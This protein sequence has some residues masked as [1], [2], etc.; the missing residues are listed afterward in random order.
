MISRQ[1]DQPMVC[2]GYSFFENGRLIIFRG[3]QE[4]A[5]IHAM[6]IWQTPFCSDAHY[7][8][9]DRGG[10]HKLADIGNR[11]LV[12]AISDLSQI[13]R[14]IANQQPSAAI[15]SDLIRTLDAVID[16]HHWLGDP[17]VGNMHDTLNTI[18]GT[19]GQVID[20]FEKVEQLRG[21][22]EQQLRQQHTAYEELERSLAI[23]GEHDVDALVGGLDSLRR[24]QGRVAGLREVRYINLEDVEELAATVQQRFDQRAERTIEHLLAGDALAATRE[25]IAQGEVAVEAATRNQ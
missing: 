21:Q 1:A 20:E 19:A 23:A 12:R 10:D 24:L 4:P 2:H 8:S 22:A 7:A 13:S 18:R 3:D 9:L 5:R 11:D 6:Q 17:S 15:Y 25:A 16:S 14:H